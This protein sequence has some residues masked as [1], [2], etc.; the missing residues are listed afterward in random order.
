MFHHLHQILFKLVV[1]ILE[2]LMVGIGKGKFF[3]FSS[4]KTMGGILVRDAQL[5]LQG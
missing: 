5:L 1:K 2:G 4:I 3:D